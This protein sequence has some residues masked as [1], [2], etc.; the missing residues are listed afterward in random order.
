MAGKYWAIVPA[1]GRGSRFG[2]PLPKQYHP[3]VG[4]TVL[5]HTIAKLDRSG[6]FEKIAVAI[7]PDDSH[8]EKLNGTYKTPVVTFEGGEERLHSVYKAAIELEPEMDDS[9][10]I[11]VHDGA[12][13]CVDLAD[14]K[15]LI[16]AVSGH[17]CGGILGAPVTDTLKRV[18]AAQQVC[19]T[20]RRDIYWK[21]FTPQLFL[22]KMLIDALE[23]RIN[24]FPVKV[25]DEAGAM[26]M[27]G[28]SPL[29]VEGQ[30]NNIKITN[31][32]DLA[33]AASIL[34]EQL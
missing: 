3:L 15:R 1:A 28:H 31:A 8:W 20:M 26:E 7:A 33:L 6:Y 23:V 29:M 24:D 14:I 18:D 12:R 30:S 16:I 19:E 13:P 9:D 5:E 21:A 2:D 22:G 25:F 27:L 11:L 32:S 10:W 34:E 17:A 4:K